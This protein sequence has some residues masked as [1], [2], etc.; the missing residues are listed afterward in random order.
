M[1][2]NSLI[3]IDSVRKSFPGVQALKDIS[4][5]ISQGEILAIVGENGAGKSTLVN[6]L[7][8]IYKSDGGRIF[9]NDREISIKNPSHARELGINV[10]FQ[11]FSLAP[12]LNAIEN[13]F[14]GREIRT[15]SGL[16][17]IN[18]M[19]IRANELLK[20]LEF[21]FDIFT[22]VK[23]LSTVEQQGIEI[24]R[25]LSTNSRIIIMD[26]PT[27][28][29]YRHEVECLFE[30]IRSLKK[31]GIS[32]VFISHILEEVL[33]ISDK[34]A[35]FRDGTLIGI[36]PTIEMDTHKIFEKM[37]GGT[38]DKHFVKDRVD[39][40]EPIFK[41]QNLTSKPKIKNI[42]FDLKRG[43]ILGIAGLTGAGKTELAEALFGARK[44][45]S[46]KIWIKEKWFRPSSPWISIRA[47][48]GLV[49]EDRK[50]HGLFLDLDV[51]KNI[52][53]VNLSKVL[54]F[55]V[56]SS[57]KEKS[58]VKEMIVKL[59]IKAGDL[60]QKVR[61]LSG[62]NQQKIVLSKW[63]FNESDILILDE[64]TRGIDVNAKREV[65]KVMMQ[66]LKKGGS[67]IL[68]SSELLELISLSDRIIV[69]QDG[70]IKAE[71]EESQISQR[72]I[73]EVM[74]GA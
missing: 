62:G 31:T 18:V 52:T 5:T 44:V 38:I 28:A 6:I 58:S 74:M 71:L 20:K 64:P 63:L 29:L 40:K 69:L 55:N 54:K 47:G 33:E 32:I 15:K 25:A 22:P 68:I 66:F 23:Y 4:L 39:I 34:V 11:E 7:A 60:F 70:E 2:A 53:I 37:I 73:M 1:D 49:P 36:Y 46:G 50:Y 10:I 14:L 21:D 26:E 72:N 16:L 17:N 45:D 27:S 43:E 8:G 9:F 61:F 24:A 30:I 19:K 12:D 42:S 35:V 56:I 3:R 67:I 51:A 65:Y 13:I 57:K 48:L 59:M 41:I